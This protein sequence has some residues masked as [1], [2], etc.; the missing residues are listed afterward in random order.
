[1]IFK[2]VRRDYTPDH[3]PERCMEDIVRTAWQHAECGRNDYTI[4][5][6]FRKSNN[7]KRNSLSGEIFL[8]RRNL[9]EY[10]CELVS[11]NRLI[12]V[13]PTLQ[14][15]WDGEYRGKSVSSADPV[16]TDPKGEIPTQ[17]G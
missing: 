11:V 3:I 17:S 7:F 13:N 1:M 4:P 10:R 15:N 9:P 5:K 12:T 14:Y 8:G 2:G 6:L 16:T